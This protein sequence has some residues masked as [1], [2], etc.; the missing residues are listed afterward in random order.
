MTKRKEF[1][2]VCGVDASKTA[3]NYYA[4][5]RRLG[6]A[7][8]TKCSKLRNAKNTSKRLIE[9]YKDKTKNRDI[10]ALPCESC[11]KPRK[12]QYRA[13]RSG[14]FLCKSCAAK[15]NRIKNVEIYNELAKKR[16]NNYEFS[17]KVSNGLM[18]VPKELRSDR[19]KLAHEIRWRDNRNERLA[20]FIEKS[21]ILHE[22]KYDYSQVEYNNHIT[23]VKIICKDHG[24]FEITPKNHALDGYG[25]PRCSDLRVVSSGHS[26]IARFLES[27]NIKISHNVK[28]IIKPYELDMVIESHAI[29]IEYHGVYWHSY[30][31]PENYKERMLHHTK[32]GLANNN[33]Y[34]LI[35]IYET[36]WVQK[37]EIIKNILLS[38]FCLTRK[39]H[40]RK[41]QLR[42]PS[43][44]EYKEFMNMNHLQG[45]RSSSYKIGLYDDDVL[46]MAIGISKHHTESFELIR[47]ATKHGY[48]IVG[49]ISRLLSKAQKDLNLTKLMTYADR[50]YST[51]KGYLSCGFKY[52]RNTNPNYFYTTGIKSKPLYSRQN[53]QKHKLSRRLERF[54]PSIS[55]S[56]NMFLN[57]YRRIWD[58]GHVKLIKTWDK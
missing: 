29:A 50:R 25:C 11:N 53:F 23:K 48:T 39:L 35:Q 30:G 21:K 49:G 6:Y 17:R 57:G 31:S 12:V 32:A 15:E 2:C 42:I 16:S 36:E 27:H 40:A 58:A 46:L 13:K 8:C 4:Q 19:S 54:N 20:V 1:I 38:K 41:Y 47:M 37:P 55:E 10:V 56:L 34:Q 9:R 33:G 18:S 24:L 7:L 43:E 14:Y 22:D 26:E 3:P 51:G 28:S 5:V 44:S 45:Y 52:V